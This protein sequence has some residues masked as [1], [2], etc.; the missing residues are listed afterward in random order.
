MTDREDY[1]PISKEERLACRIEAQL[2]AGVRHV[3][4]VG[5]ELD[6]IRDALRRP[7]GEGAREEKR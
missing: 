7:H 1:K 3:V 6:W 4:F 2:A 5:A